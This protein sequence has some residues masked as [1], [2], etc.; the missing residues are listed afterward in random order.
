MISYPL[1]LRDIMG[2]RERVIIQHP[3]AKCLYVDQDGF[4][5]ER[6]KEQII[7]SP[8]GWFRIHGPSQSI[9]G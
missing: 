4:R 5:L 6:S 9:I 2:Y 7:K 1:W 3:K 8:E